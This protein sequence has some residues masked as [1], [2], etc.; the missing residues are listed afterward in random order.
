MTSLYTR[1]RSYLLLLAPALAAVVVLI[2]VPMVGVIAVS[3]T[4]L[5]LTRAQEVRFVGLANYL[6]LVQDARFFNSVRVSG[7][8]AAGTV[9]G[10]VL[11]GLSLALLLHAEHGVPSLSRGVFLLPM[12]MPPI[13][14]S[15][16]WKLFFTPTFPGINYL[17][18]L[19]GIAGPAW[20]D[21]PL[22]ALSTIVVATT[23]KWT[24]FVM[25]ILLAALESLPREPFESAVIDGA[26]G[27]RTIVS[28]TLPML[29]PTLLFVIIYR[30]M[31]SLKMFD[32][33]YVMTAGGPGVSTEPM[34]YYAYA[35]FFQNNMMG[36]GATL[37]VAILFII[38]CFVMIMARATRG[39]A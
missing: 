33:I 27:A 21:S 34:N 28:I 38:V 5:S 15:I 36:Y 6:R 4:N 19:V 11:L 26:S 16:V 3:L 32:M 39:G 12:A 18:G 14:V 2:I 8:I 37:V 25:I 20:F 23:W 7:L 9:L 22:S 13:V 35:T 1:K 10:Q 31:E 24:P 17:L 29:R 30:T